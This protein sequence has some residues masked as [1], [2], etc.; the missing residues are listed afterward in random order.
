M[1]SCAKLLP[2]TRRDREANLETQVRLLCAVLGLECRDPEWAIPNEVLE[3]ARNGESLEA[4]R[5][6]RGQ[7]RLSLVAA[8]RL[9]D[10]VK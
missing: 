10:A 5:R 3:L 6:L 9:V 8:K 7:E 2:M 4:T 1:K